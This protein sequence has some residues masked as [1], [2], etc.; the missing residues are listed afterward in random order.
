VQGFSV[1]LVL[2]DV[3]GAASTD[4]MPSGA[5]A[6]LAD[7]KDFLPYKSYRVLDTAWIQ[8]SSGMHL[9]RSRVRGPD[10]QGYQLSLLPRVMVTTGAPTIQMRFTLTEPGEATPGKEQG[11]SP[12]TIIETTFS[13]DPGETVVVGTSRVKGDRA[14]IALLT[15]VRRGEKK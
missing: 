11:A 13:I 3:Q 6:A 2:G 4:P 8:G 12:S 10:N 7:M 5:R 1:V 15:A 14:L 9:A